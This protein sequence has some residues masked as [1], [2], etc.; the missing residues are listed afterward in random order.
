MRSALLIVLCLAA[1]VALAQEY[2]LTQFR[3]EDGLP[4]NVVKAVTQDSYGFFWIATDEGLVKYDGLDF[5]SYKGAM[6]SQYSKGFLKSRTGKLYVYGDLDLIEIVNEVDTV[7][8]REV[9][10][11][12]RNPTDSTL[13]FPKALYEDKENSLWIA[14]PQSVVCYRKGILNRF[15]FGIEDR[16][17]QFLRSFGFFEDRLGFLYTVSYSGNVY[18]FDSDEYTFVKEKV[19]F[20]SGVNDIKV[21]GNTL[22]IAAGTGLYRA[23]L[24]ESGVCT[25]PVRYSPDLNGKLPVIASHLLPLDST[26]SLLS[27]FGQLHYITN[28]EKNSWESL[29]FDINAVNSSYLSAENDIWMASNEGLILLQKNLFYTVSMPGPLTFIESITEDTSQYVMYHATMANLYKVST[30]TGTVPFA[31]GHKFV[32]TKILSIPD[33]YFQSLVHSTNGLWAANAYSVYLVNNDKVARRWDFESEGRF[34][35]DLH[36]DT[37][38]N[39][40][41]SQADNK[42]VMSI[43]P[44]FTIRRY[45]VPVKTENV[46]NCVREGKNGLYVSSN[47]LDGYLFFKPHADSV[48]RDIS[49]HMDLPTRGDFNVTDLAIT[50]SIVWMATTEGLIRFNGKT[51]QPVE[52]GDLYSHLPVKAVKVLKARYLVFNNSFGLFRYDIITGDSWRYDESNGLPSNTITT[53]G[54]YVDKYNFVWVGTSVGLGVSSHALMNDRVTTAP[55]FINAQVNGIDRRFTKSLNIPFGSYFTLN[56]SCISFPAD[57]IQMQFRIASLD[58]AWRTVQGNELTLTDL[59]AGGYTIETRA[60]KNGGYVWSESSWLNFIIQKPFW[61]QTWFSASALLFVGFIAWS[62]FGLAAYINRKRRAQLEALVNQ[63]TVELKKI[64][65]ELSMRNSELDRFVYSTSHDLSAPLKSIRGLIM[66]AK[67]ELPT[68]SQLSYLQMMEKSVRKLEMFIADVINYSRNTRT[69]VRHEPVNFRLFI[70]QLLDDHQ[71][72]P[73]YGKIEFIIEDST[74]TILMSDEMRL[75]IIFNNLISNAIKF[76]FIDE[77]RKPFVKIAA[78]EEA[79]KFI[80]VVQDNGTGIHAQLKDKIFEMFF[81]AT[82]MV[83]GSGLGLYILRETVNKLGGEVEVDTELGVGTTFVIRIPK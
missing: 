61:Q 83:Q 6:R 82:D 24:L 47:G 28:L 1:E 45:P 8:F 33:G 30:E 66:V 60:K 74:T 37:S 55:H 7:Q 56:L 70:Q 53:R 26:K 64:N 16:S 9:I 42:N 38:G 63:R 2:R 44:D 78:R 29:P 50:D 81:R 17:P 57:K 15:T 58:S 48:F 40:W 5:T 10:K 43:A 4:S 21:D 76:H 36:L 39:I 12:T 54:I 19:K 46:I 18:M 35:H 3:V 34:I 77:P 71:Y 62:S 65:D 32:S 31:S 51:L 67:M 75:K 13:W 79:D 59:P 68:E 20:P 27:T 52:L 25:Q 22:W 73:N 41:L 14:E 23:E 80:F 69:P 49:V 72:A 11:G